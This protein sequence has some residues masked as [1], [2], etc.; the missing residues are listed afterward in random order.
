V[1]ELQPAN[2]K[3]WMALSRSYAR[4]SEAAEGDEAA[5]CVKKATEAYQMFEALESKDE[6]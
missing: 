5:E 1:T 6:K 4:K 2:A 3:A